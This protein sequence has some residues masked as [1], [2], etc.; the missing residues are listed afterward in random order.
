M[1]EPVFVFTPRLG[2]HCWRVRRYRADT[3][4][5]GIGFKDDE[6][7]SSRVD[8]EA[9]K[10]WCEN[11]STSASLCVAAV[12]VVD[13]ELLVRLNMLA[14]ANGVRSWVGGMVTVPL[15]LRNI[16]TLARTVG[17]MV[18]H[19]NDLGSACL[20]RFL[21]RVS[22]SAGTYFRFIDCERTACGRRWIQ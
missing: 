20:Q 8:G 22:C 17:G 7:A 18:P 14:R 21:W 6:V 3:D 15:T 5:R 2:L 19:Y 1:D 10:E 11:S 16:T 12:V 13:G 9:T 4:Y